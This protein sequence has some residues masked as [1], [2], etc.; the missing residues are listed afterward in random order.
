MDHNCDDEPKWETIINDIE[1]EDV[2]KYFE[3][4]KENGKCGEVIRDFF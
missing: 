4:N 2:T 3:F 1:D